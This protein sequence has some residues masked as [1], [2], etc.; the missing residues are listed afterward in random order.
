MLFLKE[1]EKKK[2]KG[3]YLINPNAL[4][5]VLCEMGAPRG[6]VFLWQWE[7]RIRV[8][9]SGGMGKTKKKGERLTMLWMVVLR[10]GEHIK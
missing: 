8:D 4:Q 2:G 5:N 6:M 3:D 10:G 9:A 1:K 7:A